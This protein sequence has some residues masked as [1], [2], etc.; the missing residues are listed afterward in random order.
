LSGQHK[1]GGL[2]MDLLMGRQEAGQVSSTKDALVAD[3][4]LEGTASATGRVPI[5]Q[6]AQSDTTERT[7]LMQAP[8]DNSAGKAAH[9]QDQ[10]AR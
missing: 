3:V 6:E 1:S 4:L 9:I 10:R 8:A 2:T 7:M 5:Q